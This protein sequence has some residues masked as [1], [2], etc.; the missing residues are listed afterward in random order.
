MENTEKNTK[1][2]ETFNL[3]LYCGR[4][5]DDLKQSGGILFEWIFKDNYVREMKIC[6]I[7]F[8][9]NETVKIE[10]GILL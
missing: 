1:R 2:N 5:S 8:K 4:I 6:N 10:V 3:K 9:S 7:R